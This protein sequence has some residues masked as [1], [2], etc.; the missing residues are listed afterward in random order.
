MVAEQG[1]R[2]LRKKLN[3]KTK[4]NEQLAQALEDEKK[5]HKATYE[6]WKA[7]WDEVL[8]MGTPEE[9]STPMVEEL[10]ADAPG[11][12][13]VGRAEGGVGVVLPAE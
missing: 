4:E 13:L 11:D 7:R 5:D 1:E 8:A 12:S 2:D 10:E 9:E 6:A 3:M